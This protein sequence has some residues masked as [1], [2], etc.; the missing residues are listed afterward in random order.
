MIPRDTTSTPLA[1]FLS[2]IFADVREQ[3]EM[4]RKNRFARKVARQ[5][6]MMEIEM[7]PQKSRRFFN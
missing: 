6:F 7:I 2:E 3:R 1:R 5:N 4:L